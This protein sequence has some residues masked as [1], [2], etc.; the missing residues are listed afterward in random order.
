M[1]NKFLL[2]NL[3]FSV[4]LFFLHLIYLF[5]LFSNPRQGNPVPLKYKLSHVGLGQ[6]IQEPVAL[7]GGEKKE[8]EE[9]A[10]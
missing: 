5:N 6:C 8:A 2:N 3:I 10:S 1:P 9:G 4:Y 7:W